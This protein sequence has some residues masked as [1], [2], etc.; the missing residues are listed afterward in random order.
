MR[1]ITQAYHLTT[2]GE[3]FSI[4][5][6]NGT[7]FSLK[8]V[9]TYVDGFIEVI[10]LNKELIMIVN[11]E[12]KLSPLPTNDLA[13]LIAYKCEAISNKDYIAGD[14]VICPSVMLK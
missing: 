11:E 8:E 12:G 5:P 7:D 3:I 6:E 4:E 2:N 10:Y 13:S 1:K 9:Q 14:V